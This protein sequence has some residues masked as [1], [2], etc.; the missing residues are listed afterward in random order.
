MCL[1]GRLGSVVVV[2]ERP[3]AITPLPRPRSVALGIVKPACLPLCRQ[4]LAAVS[5]LLKA[6][7]K[8]GGCLEA[9]PLLAGS[10]GMFSW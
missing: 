4:T 3:A 9:P 7:V 1:L 2:W 5:R 6:G 8:I 10:R